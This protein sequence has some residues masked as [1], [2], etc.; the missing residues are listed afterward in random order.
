MAELKKRLVHVANV[1]Q[2]RQRVIYK[3]RVLENDQL[4]SS[5]GWNTHKRSIPSQPLQATESFFCLGVQE[6]HTLHLV[7]RMPGPPQQ[8]AGQ[9]AE[10]PG[11]SK[12]HI[13]LLQEQVCTHAVLS[14]H[15]GLL[16]LHAGHIPVAMGSL[17][18]DADETDVNAVSLLLPH[19]A[20][21]WLLPSH[22]HPIYIIH[23]S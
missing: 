5:H 4:L 2:D 1:P 15:K 17:E 21:Q 10:P 3:G 12:Q 11:Q 9:P 8:A 16:C 7:E 23:D 14:N 13:M 18:L 20:W 22:A 19:H 6:G